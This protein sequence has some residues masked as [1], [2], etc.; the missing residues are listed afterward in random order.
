MLGNQK[1]QAGELQK[2]EEQ[3]YK[4]QGKVALRA[5]VNWV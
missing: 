1:D 2:T 5:L 3:S 4:G